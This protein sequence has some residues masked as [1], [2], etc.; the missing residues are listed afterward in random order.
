MCAPYFVLLDDILQIYRIVVGHILE[1]VNHREVRRSHIFRLRELLV[2]S[3]MR[4]EIVVCVA[5]LL[6]PDS[7]HLRL[8]LELQPIFDLHRLLVLENRLPQLDGRLRERYFEVRVD[9]VVHEFVLAHAVDLGL[10]LRVARQRL[11]AA[12]F[13]LFQAVVQAL[14]LVLQVGWVHFEDA[15]L[16]AVLFVAVLAGG[17]LA[18]LADEVVVVLFS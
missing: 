8:Q 10:Q 3:G 14:D 6:A 17:G 11:V 12:L 5:L 15:V 1:L 2:E 13:G 16:G 9:L 4:H 7:L 18:D